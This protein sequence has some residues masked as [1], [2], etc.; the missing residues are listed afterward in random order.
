MTQFKRTD[1][2]V[3]SS[4]TF[5]DNLN[6]FITASIHRL[7]NIDALDSHFNLLSDD[8]QSDVFWDIT[9]GETLA[10]YLN[11]RTVVL[12]GTVEVGDVDSG[13]STSLTITGDFTSAS[14]VVTG[15]DSVI[16]LTFPSLGSV[17]YQPL[18]TFTSIDG[19][20]NDRNAELQKPYIF[21]ITQTSMS[22]G[23]SDVFG[24]GTQDLKLLIS[25]VLL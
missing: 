8:L 4:D 9:T 23:I 13:S 25:I 19:L 7:Y 10:A 12:S 5:P 1:M 3:R 21:N 17:N 16:D 14:K 22:I 2:K 15:D 11:E 20:D 24:L 6:K 18:I